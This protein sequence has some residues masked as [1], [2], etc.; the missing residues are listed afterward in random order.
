MMTSEHDPQLTRGWLTNEKYPTKICPIIAQAA[1]T[2]FDYPDDKAS[3]IMSEIK[4]HLEPYH[5]S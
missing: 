3:I 4:L 1:R 2:Q 5:K